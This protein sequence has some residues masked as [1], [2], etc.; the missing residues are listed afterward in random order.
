MYSDAAAFAVML[1]CLRDD[2]TEAGRLLE[3]EA[4]DPES[5]YLE[6]SW[7]RMRPALFTMMRSLEDRGSLPGKY[8]AKG[9]L[10]ERLREY[11][12]RNRLMHLRRAAEF[13]AIREKLSVIGVVPVPFKGFRLASA[14]YGDMGLRESSDLDVLIRPGQLAELVPLMKAAGYVSEM[15]DREQP[16]SHILALGPEYNMDL[17]EG[18]RRLHVEFHWTIAG[19]PF[20]T[21]FYYDRLGSLMEEVDWQGR[22]FVA[23]TPGGELLAAAMHHGGKEQWVRLYQLLDLWRIF[24]A[25]PGGDWSVALDWARAQG[26]SRMLLVG[27]ALMERVLGVAAPAVLSAAAAEASVQRLAAGRYARLFTP[28]KGARP[29]FFSSGSWYRI[30]VRDSLAGRCAVALGIPGHFL[31]RA[32]LKLLR[33][34][35]I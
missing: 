6:A 25:A 1:A 4:V 31:R 30:R 17:W 19:P 34:M 32:R 10:L 18:D 33:M 21:P 3:Q 23:F 29:G 26:V 16:L 24:A 14:Y 15:G 2:A 27:V 5:L 12:D 9:G 28:E 35:K 20:T 11:V 13:F 8:K 7:H 22:R